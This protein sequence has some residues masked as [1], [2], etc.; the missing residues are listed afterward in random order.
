MSEGSKV[1]SRSIRMVSV[2]DH[3]TALIPGSGS[4]ARA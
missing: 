3:G 4:T 2:E 1:N